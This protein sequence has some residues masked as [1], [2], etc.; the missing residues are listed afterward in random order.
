MLAHRVRD[1]CWWYGNRGRTFPPTF[2]YM[3]LPCGRWKQRD[4]LTQWY[5]TW[6]RVWSNDVELN[7]FTIWE[8][9]AP[10]D[11]YWCLLN[12]S[13]DQTV[14]VSTVR[15]WVVCFSRGN[16]YSGHF[17]WCESNFRSDPLLLTVLCTIN[18]NMAKTRQNY[19][20]IHIWE[21]KL[22]Q[23]PAALAAFSV[24]QNS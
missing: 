18:Q 22:M 14:D 7:S 23:L 16:S 3:L 17:Y 2:R 20:H 8:K 10:T 13:G 6:K 4:S 24:I 12:V 19:A 9:M 21:M 15:R 1:G 11:T 5:L